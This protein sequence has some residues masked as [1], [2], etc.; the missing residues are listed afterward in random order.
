LDLQTLGKYLIVL[1]AALAIV[2]GLF[3]VGGRLGLGSLPGDI[4]IQRE[5]FSCFVPIVSSI[6]LSIVL[7]L[8][9]NLLLRWF[10]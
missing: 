2:G 7:T 1:A 6:I 8:L 3:L 9:L 4:R 5:G 10:R